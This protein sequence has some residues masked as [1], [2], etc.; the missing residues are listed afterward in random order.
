MLEDAALLGDLDHAE[1]DFGAFVEDTGDLDLSAEVLDDS[2]AVG[3]AKA[4]STG[5]Q[6]LL[7]CLD[8]AVHLEDVGQFVLLD[9]DPVVRH[10][11]HYFVR[12]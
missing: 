9:A 5:G 4:Y 12:V 6:T 1:C 7:V 3:E 8:V 11:R 10:L 2:F